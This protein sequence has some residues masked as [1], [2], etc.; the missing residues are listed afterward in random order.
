MIKTV[1]QAIA[2]IKAKTGL[3]REEIA[4]RINRNPSYLSSAQKRPTST[5][6]E[7]LKEEFAN[8]L[9][10]VTIVLENKL[11]IAHISDGTTVKI[12]M[13][14]LEVQAVV[15]VLLPVIADVYANKENIEFE[16][17]YETLRAKLEDEIHSLKKPSIE[18]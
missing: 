3:S 14:S 11:K 8:E 16:K 6:I 4:E 7:L 1:K 17:A 10:G 9:A 5:I 2:M 18:P 12:K 13:N 15:N